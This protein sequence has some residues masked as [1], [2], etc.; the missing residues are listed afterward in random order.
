[1]LLSS[2]SSFKRLKQKIL[3]IFAIKS[4]T[5]YMVFVVE[6]F[7]S[8]SLIS[9]YVPHE[10][11]IMN[12]NDT[13]EM[14]KFLGVSTSISLVSSFLSPFISGFVIDYVSYYWLFMIITVLAVACFA[15]S[16]F[17]ENNY[18]D[19]PKIQTKSFIKKAI[20]NKKLKYSYLSFGLYK[21]S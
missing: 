10:I 20:S 1:M 5:L 8:F 21:V 2:I 15:I 19:A 13:N 14:K 3:L 18:V 11:I 7:Y 4:E 9:Y 12:K 17:I 16:F 6:F